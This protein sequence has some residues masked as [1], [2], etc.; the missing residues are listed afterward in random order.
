MKPWTWCH[1]RRGS[2]WQPVNETT[3]M[4]MED[5]QQNRRDFEDHI[6]KTI[7][8]QNITSTNDLNQIMN[9]LRT[10]FSLRGIYQFE[11][12]NAIVI[13]DTPARVA[14]VEQLISSS[15]QGQSRSRGRGDGDGS[16][17]EHPEGS[18]Y[19]PA[20]PSTTLSFTPRGRLRPDSNRS[21][22]IRDISN[23]TP[24]TFRSRSPTLLR[25]S[26]RRRDQQGCC[27]IHAFVQ[28]MA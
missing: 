9:V 17:S 16:G 22:P 13:H 18:W 10:A 24:A 7:Y 28:R 19:P 4:V 2:F 23:I 26:S 11:P 25:S 27:R 21:E 12:G 15:G 5:T 14:L 6:Y 1:C 20:R 3:I 8:L